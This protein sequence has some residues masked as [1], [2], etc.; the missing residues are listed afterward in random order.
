MP[1]VG[2]LYRKTCYCYSLGDLPGVKYLW[3]PLVPPSSKQQPSWQTICSIESSKMTQPRNRTFV[4]ISYLLRV[5]SVSLIICAR[6]VVTA[7][8]KEWGR[9]HCPRHHG[10]HQ[11]FPNGQPTFPYQTQL[12]T[13][14]FKSPIIS[15]DYSSKFACHVY[16]RILYMI[17]YIYICDCS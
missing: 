3:Y 12:V 2:N 7:I 16:V 13:R 9:Q 10:V 6:Y 15:S 14:P 5:G 4:Y 17:V 11:E 8:S 1:I